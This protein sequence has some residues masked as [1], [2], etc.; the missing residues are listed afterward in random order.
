MTEQANRPGIE[1]RMFQAKK[2]LEKRA[3]REISVAEIG[4]LVGRLYGG[5]PLNRERM[6]QL[7]KGA[8]PAM[9]EYDGITAAIAHVF[10][11]SRCWLYFGENAPT[12]AINDPAEYDTDELSPILPRLPMRR[13]EAADEHAASRAAGDRPIRSSGRSRRDE[14]AEPS[15]ERTAVNR[16]KSTRGTLGHRSGKR[17]R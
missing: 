15:S 2:E 11:C 8:I 10:K 14:A 6:R 4:G 17:R 12:W 1:R 5:E 16:P 7:L 13:V 9:G 3:G